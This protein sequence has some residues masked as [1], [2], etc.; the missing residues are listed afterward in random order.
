MILCIYFK[1]MVSRLITLYFYVR[2]IKQIYV[3]LALQDIDIKK[4]MV[5][6]RCFFLVFSRFL[7]VDLDN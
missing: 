6:Y 5:K 2:S 4:G 7:D 1:I 3:L